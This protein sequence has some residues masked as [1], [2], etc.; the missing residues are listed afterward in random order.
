VAHTPAPGQCG[1][2][3]SCVC[4][5]VCPDFRIACPVG[6]HFVKTPGQCCGNVG[7][8]VPCPVV[9][10]IV[11]GLNQHWVA[12]APTP[13]QCGGGSCQPCSEP[14]M[15]PQFMLACLSGTTF[16]QAPNQCCP[17]V[18]SCVATRS[19]TVASSGTSNTAIIA[20]ATVGGVALLGLVV[21]AVVLALRHRK[22]AATGLAEP[23]LQNE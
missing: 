17:N 4:S 19:S 16:E 12:Q 3:G 9:D 14:V 11:C 20:G 13:G 1:G 8:C 22:A 10:P 5:G 21:L 15:C 18:G 2:G 6:T 7:T 23:L